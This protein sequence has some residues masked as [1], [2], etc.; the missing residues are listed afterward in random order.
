MEWSVSLATWAILLVLRW[1]RTWRK[2]RKLFGIGDQDLDFKSRRD[3]WREAP[4]VR[5][6]AVSRKIELLVSET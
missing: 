4:P 5:R 6:I 2:L 3:K 1:R